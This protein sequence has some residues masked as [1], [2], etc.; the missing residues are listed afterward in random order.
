MTTVLARKSGSTDEGEGDK[1][2]TMHGGGLGRLVP[3]IIEFLSIGQL[4]LLRRH[5]DVFTHCCRD[6]ECLASDDERACRETK[7]GL[8]EARQLSL[9]LF[10]YGV[11]LQPI[12]P[13][14]WCNSYDTSLHKKRRQERMQVH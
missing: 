8:A 4:S 5:D 7:E 10:Q 3:A 13:L 9:A 6:G 11:K 2:R 14:T 1:V 12:S